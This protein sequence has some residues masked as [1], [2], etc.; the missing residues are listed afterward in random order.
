M[1]TV[2]A[3]LFGAQAAIIIARGAIILKLEILLSELLLETGYMTFLMSNYQKK[4]LV[5]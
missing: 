2:C 5:V 1:V 3:V 4:K